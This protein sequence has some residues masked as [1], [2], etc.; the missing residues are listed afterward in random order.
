M[1]E[2]GYWGDDAYNREADGDDPDSESHAYNGHIGAEEENADVHAPA[3]PNP[4]D[5]EAT[6]TNG[7]E[8]SEAT[9]TNGEDAALPGITGTADAPHNS[10]DDAKA[11]SGDVPVEN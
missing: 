10:A 5:S 1:G 4:K 6:G 3:P 7:E 11:T 9:G 8:A 2:S